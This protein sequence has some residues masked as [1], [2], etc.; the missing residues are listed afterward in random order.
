MAILSSTA[1]LLLSLLIVVAVG[2]GTGGLATLAAAAQAP[3]SPPERALVEQRSTTAWVGQSSRDIPVVY[4]VDVLVVGASSGA[5]AVA[6]EAS[7]AGASVLVA[8]PRPYLGDDICGRLQF[9]LEPGEQAVQPL[10]KEIFADGPYRPLHVKRILDQALLDAGVPFLYSC[11]VTD[12][13]IDSR[14]AVSGVVVANRAGRQ[15][16]RTKVIVDATDRAAVARM[17][18]AQFHSAAP[19]NQVFRRCVAGGEPKSGPGIAVRR[20]GMSIVPQ[21]VA[22]AA[23]SQGAD[24]RQSNRVYASVLK[25]YGV[26]EE[27]IRSAIE[28]AEYELTIALPDESFAALAEAEQLARDMTFDP[29][30]VETSEFLFHVPP[31]SMRGKV[32]GGDPWPGAGHLSLDTLRPAGVSRLYV[33][34]PCADIPRPAAEQLL[35]PVAVMELGT[36]VGA[37][38]AAEAATIETAAAETAAIEPRETIALPGDSPPK[39]TVPGEVRERLVGIRPSQRNLPAVRVPARTLPVLGRYDVVVIGGGTSGAPAALAAA[40]QGAKTL[41]VEYQHALGGV[42]TLGL[43]GNYYRGFSGGFNVELE[44]GIAQLHATVY[45]EAK[46]EWWRQEIRKAGGEIWLGCLGCGTLVEDAKVTGALVATPAGRGVVLAR[47]VID[48]TGSADAAIAAGAPYFDPYRQAFP[49]QGTGL[50]ARALGMSRNSTNWTLVDDWDLVDAWRAQ[51]HAKQRFHAAY[52]LSRLID[53]RERRRIVGDFEL[54]PL[55]IINERTYPDSIAV[56]RSDFDSHSY[57]VNPVFLLDSPGRADFR[58]HVP[59]RSLLPRELDGMLVIGLGTSADRDAV[60]LVRMQRDL[61]NRGYAAGVAAAM[62]AQLDGAVREIDIRR[63]QQHLVSIGCLE[64]AVLA[65]NDSYPIAEAQIVE[66]VNDFVAGARGAGAGHPVAKFLTQ[67][68]LAV[69]LLKSHYA[70]AGD[71]DRRLR[72]ALALAFLSDA[73][74]LDALI[75]QV[76]AIDGFDAGF[77]HIHWAGATSRWSQLDIVILALGSTGDP[78]ALEPLLNKLN[79]LIE[80]DESFSH[81]HAVCRALE[82]LGNE[83]AAPPLAKLLARTI[84]GVPVSGHA[85]KTIDDGRKF[86]DQ[87]PREGRETGLALRE[88]AI[89]RALYGC[90]DYQDLGRDTLTDYCQDLRGYFAHHARAVLERKES[91]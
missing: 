7:R 28:V 72:C 56:V 33:L 3:A 17:A 74:G 64:P 85:I 20:R 90:G 29:A 44:R 58:A 40:R 39:A 50:P 16:V 54:S 1:R 84:R 62:A 13:L 8:A 37:A 22:D 71:H 87:G 31:G 88:L 68:D 27:G 9:W 43:V 30:Q 32:Q 26:K 11:L 4:D 66:A 6:V 5:V 73:I 65:H 79:R 82:S 52:D 34:G 86:A 42:G 51:V 60:S 69:T 81:I 57:L 77:E 24:P 14:G 91:R 12:V 18:G 63:L 35:R 89:A 83:A 59:Y 49:P 41:V 25:D 78:R 48:A 55:D 70:A 53:T 61:Q 36:R 80:K 23:R 10:A 19:G 15:A 75:A 38:A 21:F 46:M 76:E 67:P 45:A 47:M 2:A